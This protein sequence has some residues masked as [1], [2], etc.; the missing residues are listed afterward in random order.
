MCIRDRVSTQST[1]DNDVG[2]ITPLN[3]VDGIGTLGPAPTPYNNTKTPS[4]RSSYGLN[5]KKGKGKFILQF[6]IDRERETNFKCY[7]HVRE[8]DNRFMQSYLLN[9]L[10]CKNYIVCLR[11]SCSYHLPQECFTLYRS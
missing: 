10:K 6:A 9:L 2:R 3:P 1:W 8:E 5:N 7:L 11:G 4:N